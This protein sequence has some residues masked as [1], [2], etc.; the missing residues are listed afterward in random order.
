MIHE[1]AARQFWMLCHALG[2]FVDRS[3]K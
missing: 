2:Y 1:S 3:Y